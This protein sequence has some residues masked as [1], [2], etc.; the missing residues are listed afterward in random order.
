MLPS[1]KPV[2]KLKVSKGVQ[3]AWKLFVKDTVGKKKKTKF[4]QVGSLDVRGSQIK[5]GAKITR[6]TIAATFKVEPTNRK[7]KKKAKPFEPDPRIFRN[8]KVV[9]GQQVATPNQWIERRRFRL[10]SPEEK[11]TLKLAPKTR[12]KRKTTT[13]NAGGLNFFQ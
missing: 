12:K 5:K 9:N 2:K 13:T 3:R 8:F 7:I 11:R 1:G 6:E 10:D 4:R